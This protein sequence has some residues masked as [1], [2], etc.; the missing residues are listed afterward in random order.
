[1]RG[2]NGKSAEERVKVMK[3]IWDAMGSEFGSRHELY[4]RNYAGSYELVRMDTYMAATMSGQ[5]ASFMEM[6]DDCMAEYDTHGWTVPDLIDPSDISA[7]Q[8]ALMNSRPGSAPNQC[9][10]G[11]PELAVKAPRSCWVV[12]TWMDAH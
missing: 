2:S 9:T 3:L 1:M 6:V 11:K 7:I 12:C 5:A 8:P 4:E 10:S